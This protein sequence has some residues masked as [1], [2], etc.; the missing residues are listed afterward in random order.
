M[1]LIEKFLGNNYQAFL[2]KFAL[3]FSGSTFSQIITLATYPILTRIFSVEEFGV[4][5]NFFGLMVVFSVIQSLKLQH[6]IVT[7]KSEMNTFY[8]LIICFILP[9]FNSVLLYSLFQFNI[10][11]FQFI[12]E[13]NLLIPIILSG[14]LMVFYDVGYNFL[15]KY[16]LFKNLVFIKI[17]QNSLI[18]IFQLLYGYF[19]ND[20]ISIPFNNGLIAGFIFGQLL[21]L[22]I[23][24]FVLLKYLLNRNKSKLSLSIDKYRKILL[25]HKK[26]IYFS[27][28]AEF[29]NSLAYYLVV[30]FITVNFG[31]F[32]AGLYG[33]SQR[34]IMGP[35]NLISLSLLDI[36]KNYAAEEM[37]K[38][39]SIKK[40]YNLM[41][42][43]LTILSIFCLFGILIFKNFFG[44]IFGQEWKD[45]GK[46]VLILT[47]FYLTKFISNPLSYT[48]F[49]SKKQEIDLI[50][51]VGLLLNICFIF[52]LSDDFYRTLSVFTILISTYYLFNLFLSYKLSKK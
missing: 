44:L 45:V 8:L 51:Q 12:N 4:F 2:K 17:M 32:Y 18:V 37:N 36:F 48:F 21:S 13:T 49:L 30:Y 14:L 20:N 23:L 52:F 38:F 43:I 40:S 24:F 19:L 31:I 26:F 34:V 22:L 35:L 33:L 27:M 46:I 42:K 15:A 6:A 11:F 16:G 10:S 5:T 1:K 39:N 25:S 41:L 47:P 28:P 9:I 3:V 50:W 29:I 7:E